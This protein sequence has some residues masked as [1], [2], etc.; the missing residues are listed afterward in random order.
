MDPS[1]KGS[2]AGC[3]LGAAAAAGGCSSEA[4]DDGAVRVLLIVF[5]L[6][7]ALRRKTVAAGFA[8]IGISI[9]LCIALLLDLLPAGT[10]ASS[11]VESI[12]RWMP[13]ITQYS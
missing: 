7:G 11:L 6:P 8:P 5:L 2:D 1:I 4:L 10:P 3:S 9:R 13:T 12:A